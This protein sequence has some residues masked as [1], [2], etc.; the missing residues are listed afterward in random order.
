MEQAKVSLAHSLNAL[1]NI[2]Q[3]RWGGSHQPGTGCKFLLTGVY[4]HD[5]MRIGRIEHPCV[6][7][8]GPELLET[9][10]YT[11]PSVCLL[12]G[13]TGKGFSHETVHDC[14][15][16]GF[17]YVSGHCMLNLYFLSQLHFHQVFR[18]TAAALSVCCFVWLC[19]SWPKQR[20]FLDV[21]HS[22]ISTV[23]WLN[24]GRCGLNGLKAS[25]PQVTCQVIHFI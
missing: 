8:G 17:I 12:G 3:L 19:V 25:L 23:R 14:E 11:L 5:K 1:W 21:H 18:F 24:G 20:A 13:M 15:Y 9:T 10:A 16:A 7:R 22:L 2:L 6:K 4:Q